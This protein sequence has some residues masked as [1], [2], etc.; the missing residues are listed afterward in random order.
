MLNW[1]YTVL[2]QKIKLSTFE[3]IQIESIIFIHP[4]YA[5]EKNNATSCFPI[6]NILFS[7]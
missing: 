4:C 3:F 7:S 1:T 6:I 2:F 5:Q